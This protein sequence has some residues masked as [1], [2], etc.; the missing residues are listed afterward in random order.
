M[1]AIALAAMA[2]KAISSPKTIGVA[3]LNHPTRI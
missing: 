3:V 1:E 2:E